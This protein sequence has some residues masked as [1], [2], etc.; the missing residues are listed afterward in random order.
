MKISRSTGYALLAV[1]YIAQ[2]QKEG[3]ILSQSVSK[4]YNIPLEYLLKILQQLVRANVLRSKRG[5]RGGFS[6]A[7]S[8]KKITL[9]QVVEAV[10]G[11][12]ISHL[13]LAEQARGE[14]FAAR[15]ERTYEKAIAQART[16]FE[17]AKIADLLEA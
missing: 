5:P 11:P 13:N 9:L 4:K 16:V 12:M 1:G 7:K 6:L 15:A 2:H 10:E 14:K 17:K 8:T 3:I